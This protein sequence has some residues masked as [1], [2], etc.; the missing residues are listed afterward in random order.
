MGNTTEEFYIVLS[1]DHIRGMWHRCQWGTHQRYVTSL[2]VVIKS[3]VYHN[4]F[5]GI[6]SEERD[7][8]VSDD[9]IRGVSYHCQWGSHQRVITTF[10]VEITSKECDI[11][12]SG[13]QIR[14]LSHRFQWV[15][16]KKRITSLSVGITSVG[17]NSV[18]SGNHIRGMSHRQWVTTSERC[19]IVF[20][21]D[22]NRGISQYW[23]TVNHPLHSNPGPLNSSSNI[24]LPLFNDR[25][26][27]RSTFDTG[28]MKIIGEISYLFFRN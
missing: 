3:K 22:Y 5:R 15:S 11:V 25:G 27:V 20:S 14:G 24:K 28:I 4:V 16:H 26:T 17:Y 9:V 6:T 12:V 21:G 10:W 23:K 1:D 7:I 8:V 19:H 13:D 2:S 18:V